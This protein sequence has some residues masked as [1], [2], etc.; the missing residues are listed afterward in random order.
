MG[1]ERFMAI[2]H[3]R[4]TI[5]FGIELAHVRLR[6][7]IDEQGQEL[8][9]AIVTYA[10]HH[11]FALV[12]QRQVEIGDHHALAVGQRRGE[13]RAFRRYDR[14]K[15][16]AA[17]RALEASGAC[18]FGDLVGIE[19]ASGVDHEAAGFERVVP[20]RDLDLLAEDLPHERAREHGNV[21]LLVLGH[22]RVASEWI[23]VLPA[24]KGTDPTDG[25]VCGA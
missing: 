14:S 2:P 24:R 15:T 6:S 10:V 1:S 5:G 11:A 9:T 7:A 4:L 21:D 16:A 13:Q 25:G 17:E 18:H 20:N 19:V 3:W 22:H 23:V 8:G 12:D